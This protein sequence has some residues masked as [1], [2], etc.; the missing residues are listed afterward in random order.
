[1]IRR[2][3]TPDPVAP[4]MRMWGTAGGCS[5]HGSPCQGLPGVRR[6]TS[7]AGD[8]APDSGWQARA[9]PLSGFCPLLGQDLARGIHHQTE[10]G[11]E[12]AAPHP[13]RVLAL[14]PGQPPPSSP[15]AVRD[16]GVRSCVATTST[17][18]CGV[19]AR[20][21]TGCIMRQRARGVTG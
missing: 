20:A 21:W 15:G 18:A 3:D 10:D 6:Q 16:T 17:M 5:H 12:A 4:R 13:G 1:M 14:V 11:G 7:D 19:T 8:A 9:L 2:R